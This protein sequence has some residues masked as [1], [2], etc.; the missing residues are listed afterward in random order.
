MRYLLLLPLLAGCATSS[1]GLMD[2]SVAASFQSQRAPVEVSG[3]ISTSLNSPASVVQVSAD[4]YAIMRRNGVGM[5]I[6]RY[7]V[8]KRDAVTVVEIRSALSMM[9]ARDKVDACL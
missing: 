6:V 7:D 2:R 3:C 1:D 8:F 9:E 5:P 4:H